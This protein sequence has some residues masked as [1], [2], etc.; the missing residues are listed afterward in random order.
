MFPSPTWQ[1]DSQSCLVSS[2]INYDCPNPNCDGWLN[3]FAKTGGSKPC[4]LRCVNSSKNENGSCNVSTIFSNKDGKYIACDNKKLK[5]HPFETA[6][7]LFIYFK[8]GKI[9]A[10]CGESRTWFHA[11]TQ[12]IVVTCARC[13]EVILST[14]SARTI[15]I[16]RKYQEVHE[17][18]ANWENIK[19]C[20]KNAVRM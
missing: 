7:L 4:F 9:L 3:T 10:S 6:N 17:K 5:F 14:K 16:C 8:K 12:E 19:K 1:L 13:D 2:T 20:T 18:C 11:M 15:S